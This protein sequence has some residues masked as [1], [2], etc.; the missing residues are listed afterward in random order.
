[1]ARTTANMWH[2][3]SARWVTHR[4]ERQ[5]H[6]SRG[7]NRR[8]GRGFSLLESMLLTIILGTVGAGV[9]Q[10]LLTVAKPPRQN[11]AQF[12]I[13]M[14]LIAQMEALRDLDFSDPALAPGTTTSIAMINGVSYPCIITVALADPNG[15]NTPNANFKFIQVQIGGGSVATLV[16]KP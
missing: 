10:C 12:Q 13:D 1:M 9:G 4:L 8:R 16:N 14:A 6:G 3:A 5:C 7:E 11:E 15:G 2:R